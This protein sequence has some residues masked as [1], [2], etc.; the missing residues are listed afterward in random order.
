[1]VKHDGYNRTVQFSGPST[2]INQ[3]RSLLTLD[4]A[5]QNVTCFRIVLSI[6]ALLA[7]KDMSG[8]VARQHG[9]SIHRR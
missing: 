1:M 6:P 7:L 2:I 4:I 3:L 9:S 5:R 8:S